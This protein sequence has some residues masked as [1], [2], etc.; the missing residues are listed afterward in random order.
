MTAL[1]DFIRASASYFGL[2]LDQLTVGST[3]DT[4]NGDME[5]VLRV[6]L[7]PSD[8]A[9]IAQRMERMALEARV[10]AQVAQ[11]KAEV[12]APPPREVM[13]EAYR[14]LSSA[15]RSAYG[16]FH[17]YVQ[18]HGGPD[19]FATEPDPVPDPFAPDPSLEPVEIPK[20]VWLHP[21]AATEQQKA[22]AIGVN[23]HGY[24]GL[25]PADLTPEQAAMPMY[26]HVDG[27]KGLT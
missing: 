1:H 20:V 10:D 24:I 5:V 3:L 16:S 2:P 23:E 17:R 11:R 14:N 8:V 25:D 19:P 22:M 27:L 12:P 4:T 21:N 7:L 13:R 6:A 15:E 9:E 26:P 18:E